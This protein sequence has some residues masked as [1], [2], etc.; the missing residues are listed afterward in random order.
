[1]YFKISHKSYF[2]I[3]A[4]MLIHPYEQLKKKILKIWVHLISK[5]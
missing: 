3:A 2:L 1:M 4:Q 5:N